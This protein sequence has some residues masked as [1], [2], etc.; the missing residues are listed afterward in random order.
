MI[1]FISTNDV[2]SETLRRFCFQINDSKNGTKSETF[3]QRRKKTNQSS[4]PILPIC[5]PCLQQYETKQFSNTKAKRNHVA[6][7]YIYEKK[8]SQ[9]LE[10]Q[11]LI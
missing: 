5:N 2:K 1:I 10:A 11:F 4:K 6:F 9:S 3:A 8:L 7:F